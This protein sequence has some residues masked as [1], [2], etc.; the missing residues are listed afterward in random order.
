MT[1]FLYFYYYYNRSCLTN[2]S[3]QNL[4]PNYTGSE[5]EKVFEKIICSDCIIEHELLR[6]NLRYYM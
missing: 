1:A 4:G 3:Q 2:L 5:A 6:M